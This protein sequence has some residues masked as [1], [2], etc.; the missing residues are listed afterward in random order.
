MRLHRSTSEG[1]IQ[2]L[3]AIFGAKKYADKVIEKVLK[4]NPKWGARDR[5]FIA[6]TTYDIVRWYRLLRRVTEAKGDEYWKLLA[7]WC[8][9][10]E[11]D[12]PMWD[13]FKGIKRDSIKSLYKEAEKTRKIIES[14]PDWLDELCEREIGRQW[15]HELHALNEEAAVV[16]RTN[17]LKISKRDLQ[18]LLAEENVETHV[19]DQ[20]QD[21][22]LLEERQNVFGTSAFKDGLFEVQDAASQFIAPFLQVEPGMRVIDACAGAGGK[23]LHL[24]ALMKNKGRIIA[25][26]VEQYKLD[27][28]QRR[29]RRAGVSNMETRLIESSKTV[30]RLEDNADR[31]LLDVPCS[32]LGVLKRNPDA[33]WKLSIEFIDKVKDLQQ[34]ILND[35][36]LM[37]KPGGLLVYSTCSILPSENDQQIKKFLENRRDEFEL[38]EEKHALPSEGFDGFYMARLKRLK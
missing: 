5:R 13:E 31:L 20:F 27:E 35:Y 19:H 30:K 6:E 15:N 10:H 18:K 29:A 24:A 16:L 33:K 21:A 37:V 28:L 25:M 38:Q 34:H 23:T 26:D 1:V 11:I 36:C 32:G 12:L 3:D 9:L 4:Q 22:L 2:A 8:V 7:A 17:T 14:V